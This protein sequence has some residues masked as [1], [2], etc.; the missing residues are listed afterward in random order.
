MP[1]YL[2]I[3]GPR[4]EPADA[5]GRPADLPGLA[6]SVSGARWL[7]TYSPDLHDDRHVSLWEAESAD[8]VRAAMEAFHFFVEAETT[9]FRVHEWGPED[10]R[11]APTDG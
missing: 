6:R 3:H 7:R 8:D 2:A 1:R 4:E 9:V 10:V 5:P 11:A